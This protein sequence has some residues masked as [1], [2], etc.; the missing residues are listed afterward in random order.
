MLFRS[1]L[2]GLLSSLSLVSKVVLLVLLGFS[3]FSWALILYKWRFFRDQEA[4]DER[5]LRAFEK[6]HDPLEAFRRVDRH[7]SSGVAS[8]YAEV[9]KCYQVLGNGAIKG[10]EIAPAADDDKIPTQYYVERILGH[11]IQ[12]QISRN[13]TYL[14]FLATTGNITPF[15]GLLGTVLG[16]I[17]AFR[18]IGVQGTASISAVAPGVAEALVATA[19]GLF[20]ALPAV[21]AYNYF[22]GRVRRQASRMERFGIDWMNVLARRKVKESVRQS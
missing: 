11:A 13:E 18:E 7:R 4:A 12:E 5:F 1:G 9:A 6:V 17:D 15:I 16:I 8:I 20:A 19:A 14:P 22:L 21:I 10:R 2:F 3:I